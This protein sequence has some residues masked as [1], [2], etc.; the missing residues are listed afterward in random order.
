MIY[1]K[2][3]P[4]AFFCF[5]FLLGCKNEGD[6]SLFEDKTLIAEDKNSVIEEK[7]DGFFCD[8]YIKN[9]EIN[10][11]LESIDSS[12][13]KNNYTELHRVF[14][15]PFTFRKSNKDSTLSY[16]E[17]KGNPKKYLPIKDLK[18]IRE[19]LVEKVSN[20]GFGGSWR[21]CTLSRGK[22]WFHGIPTDNGN[23]FRITAFKI[24]E[25]WVD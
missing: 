9:S 13:E 20:G 24:D 7:I 8:I 10:K 3:H 5:Y 1:R 21:G 4:L 17:F 19:I 23:Q 2:I 25:E 16:E 6:N 22:I 11:F 12:I 14:A 15:F 18:K